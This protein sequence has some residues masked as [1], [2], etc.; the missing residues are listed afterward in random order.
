MLLPHHFT[1]TKGLDGNSSEMILQA[2]YDATYGTRV[3]HEIVSSEKDEQQYDGI[4]RC[5][6]STYHS[7]LGSLNARG[8][9]VAAPAEPD[10]DNMYRSSLLNGYNLVAKYDLHGAGF[11]AYRSTQD[12]AKEERDKAVADAK[13]VIPDNVLDTIEELPCASIAN[14]TNV[15]LSTAT[16]VQTNPNTSSNEPSLRSTSPVTRSSQCKE[17]PSSFPQR[18]RRG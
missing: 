7:A 5:F 11:A 13:T 15:I 8:S 6:A 3:M 10:G 12:L 14:S 16:P 17:A 2:T 9:Y 1:E 4:A 18:L